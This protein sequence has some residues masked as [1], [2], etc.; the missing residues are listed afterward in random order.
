MVSLSNSPVARPT[1]PHGSVPTHPVVNPLTLRLSW[2]KR[3]FLN[4]RVDRAQTPVRLVP[5]PAVESTGTPPHSQV[6]D[7]S[8]QDEED[9][10][11][12]VDDADFCCKYCAPPIAERRYFRTH[13]ALVRHNF[14]AEHWILELHIWRQNTV[15]SRS[16]ANYEL[17]LTVPDPVQDLR[18]LLRDLEPVD[19]WHFIDHLSAHWDMPS[20]VAAFVAYAQGIATYAPAKEAVFEPCMH[21]PYAMRPLPVPVLEL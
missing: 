8:P 2:K 13:D 6:A 20:S 11:G 16:Y 1:R 9:T 10:T 3:I 5:Q 4:A 14:D 15:L 19:F 7:V 21:G 12:A 17:Y 18:A